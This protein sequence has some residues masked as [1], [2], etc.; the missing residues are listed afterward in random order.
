MRII[1]TG[2]YVGIKEDM[3]PQKALGYI[4]GELA[5]YWD[6]RALIKQILSFL[7]DAQDI[8][9][10]QPHWTQPSKMAEQLLAAVEHDS[11]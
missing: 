3:E 9:N 1:F 4:K 11:V 7:V 5:D 2:I 10:M 8:T 6:K